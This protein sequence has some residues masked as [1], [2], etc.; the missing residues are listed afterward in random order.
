VI[1]RYGLQAG[2]VRKEAVQDLKYAPVPALDADESVFTLTTD[3]GVHYARTVVLAIGP[4]NPPNIPCIPGMDA[5]ARVC[6]VLPCCH[7]MQI[8]RFPDPAVTAKIAAKREMNVIVVGA[9]LTSAQLADM[10]IRKGVTRVWHLMR[11]DCKVKPFD[12]DL[13]WMGKFRNLEQSIFWSADSDE[14]E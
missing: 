9:G 3:A 11:G 12:V 1:D 6:S 7:S 2:L 10:A 8:K 14:G 13:P 4:A 5:A